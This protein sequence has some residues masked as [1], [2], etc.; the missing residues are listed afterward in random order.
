MCAGEKNTPDAM[1][2]DAMEWTDEALD[3]AF[4]GL[5]G[6]LDIDVADAVLARLDE[7]LPDIGDVTAAP[8]FG[9]DDAFGGLGPMMEGAQVAETASPP[10][11]KESTKDG[12]VVSL[13]ERRR[14]RVPLMVGGLAAAAA[15][16]LVFVGQPMQESSVAMME[17]NAAVEGVAEEMAAAPAPEEVA[18]ETAEAEGRGGGGGRDLGG[19]SWNGRFRAGL[20]DEEEPMDE[21]DRTAELMP[22]S[23]LEQGVGRRESSVQTIAVNEHSVDTPVGALAANQDGDG[24]LDDAIDMR[25][26]TGVLADDRSQDNVLNMPGSGAPLRGG[27]PRGTGSGATVWQQE[28]Q[29][30]AQ[31]SEETGPRPP[32]RRARSA[33]AAADPS[34][35]AVPDA[36]AMSAPAMPVQPTTVQPTTG[37]T[38]TTRGG[39]AERTANRRPAADQSESDEER[40]RPAFETTE[41]ADAEN[42]EPRNAAAEAAPTETPRRSLETRV[43]S[44]VPGRSSL[45][46]TSVA[47]SGRVT[48][49]EVQGVRAEERGCLLRALHGQRQTNARQRRRFTRR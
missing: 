21:F 37:A 17:S 1:A 5:A 12:K 7:A 34:A 22:E 14:S 41:I 29:Q 40:E 25:D 47:E 44:C 30:H 31:R 35:G 24:R 36:P 42:A 32:V 13:A 27:S 26:E 4:A 15:I 16:A 6:E 8:D 43:L 33:M 9:P 39:L 28:Q 38:G 3:A 23:E 19:E 20:D 18:T 11:A 48:A 45:T 2:E 46:L 49:I 10:T